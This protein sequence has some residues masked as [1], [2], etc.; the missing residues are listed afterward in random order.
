MGLNGRE[1]HASSW[2]MSSGLS[3]G[4]E[5]GGILTGDG[6]SGMATTKA[7]AGNW[8]GHSL[9]AAIPTRCQRGEGAMVAGT[10]A[11]VLG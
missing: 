11:C 2:E 4:R 1:G 8:P 3:M 5:K 9:T 7:L 10:S 6:G